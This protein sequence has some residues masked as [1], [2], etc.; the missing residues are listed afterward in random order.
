M[1]KQNYF[2]KY[3]CPRQF[4]KPHA[5]N[6]SSAWSYVGSFMNQLITSENSYLV[7]RHGF[8]VIGSAGMQHS[9]LQLIVN[10]EKN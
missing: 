1:L 10:T 4:I 3:N 8:N 5:I 6:S 2:K 7:Q 9:H